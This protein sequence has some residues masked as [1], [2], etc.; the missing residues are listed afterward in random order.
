MR[1]VIIMRGLPGSGKGKKI[2]EDIL[3][4]AYNEDRLRPSDVIVVSADHY[5]ER[6]EYGS[7]IYDFDPAK[8][9]LA[10]AACMKRF[11]QAVYDCTPL[12]VV[13]NTNSQKWEFENYTLAARLND[14]KVEIEFASEQPHESKFIK[15]DDIRR[16]A[17]RNT[18]GVPLAAVAA[19]AARWED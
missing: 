4:E 15:V 14:Y 1:K 13:D 5:F 10:H 6:E 19:M 16:F 7:K 8:L 18:H 11:L 2:E 3:V 12:I 17:A 9:P